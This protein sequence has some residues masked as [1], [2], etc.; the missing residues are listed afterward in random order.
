MRSQSSSE[1]RIGCAS[2]ATSVVMSITLK[3]PGGRKAYLAI[4]SQS[5][6]DVV[7]GTG[8]AEHDDHHA[9]AHST[10]EGKQESA[11][12]LGVRR[13]RGMIGG[14]NPCEGQ[15]QNGTGILGRMNAENV[16]AVCVCAYEVWCR[17]RCWSRVRARRRW[18][19]GRVVEMMARVAARHRFHTAALA[20]T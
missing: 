4:F 2:N 16:A 5:T 13:T 11:N 7:S 9:C 20:H 18:C 1:C 10:S 12:A 8:D 3:V 15:P 14:T 6:N 17:A 19:L